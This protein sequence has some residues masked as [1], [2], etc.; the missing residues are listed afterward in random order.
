MSRYR[1]L[2]RRIFLERTG[3][4]GV[5]L[6]A[7]RLASG[8][9]PEER[10]QGK[11]DVKPVA[12]SSATYRNI[13]RKS[14][15]EVLAE[16]CSLQPPLSVHVPIQPV[17]SPDFMHVDCALG[18]CRRR[19]Y[20]LPSPTNPAGK[21]TAASPIDLGALIRQLS[22]REAMMVQF[23]LDEP[24]FVPDCRLSRMGL[25]EGRYPLVEAEYREAG[26]LYR[27]EYFCRAVDDGQSL[28]WIRAAVT[29]E[30]KTPQA[31]HVRIKV[32][33]QREC[34]VFPYHYSPFFWDK[35]KW[36][37]C[38]KVRLAGDAIHRDSTPI[39]KVVAGGFSCRWEP[40]ATFRDEQFAARFGGQGR[41]PIPPEL[42]LGEIQN[43][44][45]M[46]AEL[47]PA[48][49]KGFAVA[50]LTNYE[51]VTAGHREVLARAEADS[52]RRESLTHFSSQCG[53]NHTQ[54]VCLQDRW[55]AIATELQISTLQMLV[56]FPGQTRLM[57]TQGGSSE[58]HLV[59]VWEAMCMLQPM[60]RL[61]HFQAVRRSL[62]YIFSLQDAGCPPQGRLVSTAGS[63]GTTGP[64]WLNTTGSALALAADYEE[65][66]RDATFLAEYL[67]KIL[68]GVGWIVGEL[69]GTRKLNA[70]GSRP[71]YYGL[72]PFGCA[73]DG[74]IGYI[75]AFTDA[76]TFWGLEKTVR[77]LERIKHPQ[78]EEFR[79][80]LELYRTD[81]GRAMEAMTRPDGF[82]E[83]K[84]LTGQEKHLCPGFEN[85]CSAAT[86]AHTG[87]LDVE[88]DRFRRFLNYFEEHRMEGYFVGMM[89]R[90][91]AYMGIGEH[92]WQN[93]YL[94]LG[95]WKKAFAA[96]RTN[97][98]YGM[99]QDT[100]QVQER[101]ALRNPAFTPWQPNGSGNGR[102][103]EMM[104]NAI[105]FEHAGV[106]TLL[107]GIPFPWLVKNGTTAL[108]RFHTPR[109]KLAIE[110]RMVDNRSCRLTLSAIDPGALPSSIRVPN[111]LRVVSAPPQ[112]ANSGGGR[113]RVT[114]SPQELG[115]LVQRQAGA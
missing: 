5:S 62:E 99:T 4:V 32:D 17:H 13:N 64:K 81:L 36:R 110:A 33:F 46:T 28:L 73:T 52:C 55:D 77:L 114:A 30:H 6:A 115:F 15:E 44:I 71:A 41:P 104:L 94:R 105:Y 45:H 96:M 78:A 39:G 68:K 98:R 69:R 58:R 70:D 35:T 107:G 88:S 100:F 31:A 2:S 66:A 43:V 18:V 42:R 86:L 101:L 22:Q 59:W 9:A 113:Y 102:I 72:M 97:L 47:R 84:I 89:D 65:Y 108:R 87:C 63:V 95:E 8:L 21:G 26:F 112:A 109:G 38:D 93:I 50:L 106:A 51:N 12:E 79:R 82:I 37:P 27:F 1:G 76:Y 19:V 7:G 74:D 34:D 10:A 16:Q 49:T 11:A 80:E 3:L 29:N 24:A 48:E 54:L 75:V 14:W 83:R 90:N 103:L 23:A 67:P 60:L 25:T 57:P 20:P 56:L 61:G 85:I 40:A 111:H 92:I 53:P 91:V